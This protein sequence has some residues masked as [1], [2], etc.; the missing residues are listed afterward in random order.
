MEKYLVLGI[1]AAVAVVATVI[2]LFGIGKSS[3]FSVSLPQ[4]DYA[5]ANSSLESAVYSNVL[6]LQTYQN[7][8]PAGK[9]ASYDVNY[10][11]FTSSSLANG[12][13]SNSSE[14]SRGSIRLYHGLNG[15]SEA[16]S[17]FTMSI[18][19]SAGI[20]YNITSLSYVFAIGNNTYLCS[21]SSSTAGKVSC[22]ALNESMANL[23]DALLGGLKLNR[24]SLLKAYNTTYRG[25]PCLFTVSSFDLALNESNS[26]LIAGSSGNEKLSGILTSCDYKRY[27]IT[28]MSSLVADLSVSIDLNG[29]ALNSNSYISYN[30][31][32]LNI[33]NFA[34]DITKAGLP[35]ASIK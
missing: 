35:N 24:V 1:I 17:N 34:S 12:S 9:S 31:S 11:L 32:I 22:L 14:L 13:G 25:Y 5:A 7:T 6:G 23:S 16:F 19:V 33:G 30:E 10:S 3:N 21:G 28:V 2:L 27:N 8:L 15:N 26:S 29:T 4:Q 20:T 18:P